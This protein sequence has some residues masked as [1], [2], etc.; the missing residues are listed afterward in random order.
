MNMNPDI[1]IVE[2]PK[3][4]LAAQRPA[5]DN[6]LLQQPR[7]EADALADDHDVRVDVIA[8]PGPD[9]DDA[10]VLDDE[11]L[12]HGLGEEHRPG[13]LSLLGEPRVEFHAQHRVGV[14]MLAVSEVLVIDAD[15]RL[16]RHDPAPFLDDRAFERRLLPGLTYDLLEVVAVEDSTHDVLGTWPDTALEERHLQ[17]GLGHSQ[18]RRGAGGAGADHNRVK[19]FVVSH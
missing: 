18:G 12:D 9:T 4:Q 3:S 7:A 13:F 2:S 1:P 10:P 17:P 19:F 5:A 14:W 6:G 16:R 11:T 8:A 15:G